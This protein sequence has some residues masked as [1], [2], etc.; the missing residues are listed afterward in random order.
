MSYS[1]ARIPY[2]GITDLEGAK[3]LAKKIFDLYD[4]NRTGVLG[5][6]E[7]PTM[8]VD[9][10]RSMNKGFQPSNSDIDTYHKVLDKDGDGRI[11]IGDIEELAVRYLVGD[12]KSQRRP[13]YTPDVEQRLDL[14]RRLF[15]KIDVDHSNFITEEEVPK[16]LIET[17]KSMGMTFVPSEDDV[18]VWMKMTDTDSDGKVTLEEYEDLVIKSLKNAGI[19]VELV[20]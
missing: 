16:L 6:Q 3:A 5:N 2:G 18:K 14:A 11:T 13:K 20:S 10:Y 12:V 4:S 1:N 7:L 17:Y 9:C 15:R 8:M 19:K